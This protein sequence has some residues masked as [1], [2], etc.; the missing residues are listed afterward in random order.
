MVVSDSGIRNTLREMYYK[1]PKS[2]GRVTE[3]LAGCFF[4]FPDKIF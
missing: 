2:L 1:Q 3:L 4:E